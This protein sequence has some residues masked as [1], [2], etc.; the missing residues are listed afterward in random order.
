VGALRGVSLRKALKLAGWAG[1]LLAVSGCLALA[2]AE[3]RPRPLPPSARDRAF[4]A[5]IA[6]LWPMAETLG[7]KRKTF[8]AAFAGVAFDDKVVAQ[9]A[10]QAEFTLPIWTY[11][12]LAVSPD[13]IAR[14]RDKARQVGP[15]LEKAG[16]AYGVDPGVLMGIWGLETDFGAAPGS[17]DVVRSLASL[18]F[19][20]YR[21]TFFRDE[22]L[23]ALAILEAGDVAP[24][25]MTG[26]WA[27]AMGQTQFMPSSFLEYAVDFSGDGRRDIWTSQAD[28]IGSAAH[29][30]TA[31]GWTRGLPWGFEVTLPPGFALADADSSKPASFLMFVARGVTR[32]DGKPLP[33]TGAARLFFPAGSRGPVFLVTSNFDVIKTYNSATVYALA[34]AL[35]GDAIMGG[36][37]LVAPWPRSDPALTADDVRNLQTRLKTMGYDPGEVDGMVGDALR[38]AVRKYQEKNGLP[39]DGYADVALLNRIE[40]SQ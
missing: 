4:S 35:L 21:E 16:A 19:V 37:S 31:N 24:R 36:S 14:G 25:A 9:T 38:S 6:S 40:S 8:E 15:W 30:L 20:K 26:S 13:R 11:I 28:A 32:S 2:S 27:G 29:Y 10:H 39:P 17:F 23:S 1:A 34:V 18:A 7:V 12:G 33:A 5:F 3:T 22:L